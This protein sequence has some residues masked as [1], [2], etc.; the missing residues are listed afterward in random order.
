MK[1]AKVAQNEDCKKAEDE[2]LM[3]KGD[4]IIFEKGLDIAYSIIFKT[5]DHA[6]HKPN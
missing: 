5:K 1:E 4:Q 6:N 2:A 3:S